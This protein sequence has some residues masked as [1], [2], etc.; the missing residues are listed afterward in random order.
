MLRVTLAARITTLY[1]DMTYAPSATAILSATLATEWLASLAN[2]TFFTGTIS[3]GFI[4]FAMVI[5]WTTPAWT[6]RVLLITFGALPPTIAQA[7]ASITA[8]RQCTYTVAV[9]FIRA[10]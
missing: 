1:I 8:Q 5:T 7:H 3:R 4:A 2:K 6:W 9:A 10:V